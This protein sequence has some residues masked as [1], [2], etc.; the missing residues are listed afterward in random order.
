[1]HALLLINLGSP[2]SP[3]EA[4]VGTYLHEFLND[5]YVIDAP[6][7]IRRPLVSWI[8]R[9]RVSFSAHAYASIWQAEGSPLITI[10][11][12]L[13][14]K[15][16]ASW[17][18]GPVGLAMR[19]GEPSITAALE[20]L[21]TPETTRLTIIPLYPQFTDSTVTTV[22]EEVR[23][24]L[25]EGVEVRV[26]PP[27]FDDP[28]YLDAL[29]ATLAAEL[30]EV[31]HLLFSFHGVPA[32]HIRRHV[33]SDLT[34]DP[35]DELPEDTLQLCYRSQC[36]YVARAAAE[37][38]GLGRDQWSVSF[39]SRLGRGWIEPFTEQRIAELALAGTRSLAVACPAFVADCLETLEEIGI[40]GR[41][42]FAENGGEK[43]TLLPCL[44]DAAR[45][46][47]TIA[48]LADPARTVPFGKDTPVLDL[49]R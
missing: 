23:G 2:A 13:R 16:A 3:S 48:A 42:T 10:S 39:Q 26:I 45:W 6:A 8:I 20:Q 21:V 46:A 40:R 11:E 27:F 30:P 22:L 44:N 41:E 32:R 1:M 15:V 19:Y 5:P 49:V 43:F 12:S 18:H 9:R 25:P 34:A 28:D 29:T 33:D 17:P 24:H 4:D 47:E 38:L 36:L 37:R 35:L 14:E 31:D 7:L